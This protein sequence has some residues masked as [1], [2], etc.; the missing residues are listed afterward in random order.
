MSGLNI[1]V[2]RG[3]G[4]FIK[5]PPEEQERQ[6]KLSEEAKVRHAEQQRLLSKVASKYGTLRGMGLKVTDKSMKALDHTNHR[7]VQMAQDIRIFPLMVKL[8]E[9]GLTQAHIGNRGGIFVTGMVH[10][11]LDPNDVG[12]GLQDRKKTIINPAF[13]DHA[14]ACKDLVRLNL[15]NHGLQRHPAEKKAQELVKLI[16]S[17]LSGPAVKE[18]VFK[19]R[20]RPAVVGSGISACM[21]WLGITE[22]R[23]CRKRL[24]QFNPHMDG[25]LK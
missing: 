14:H 1:Q 10:E 22:W 9:M 21:G 12:F 24:V 18:D 7:S 17:D 2:G 23:A 3:D 25:N 16:E 19:I 5:P 13:V 8:S 11:T 15:M 20:T 4:T 6:R